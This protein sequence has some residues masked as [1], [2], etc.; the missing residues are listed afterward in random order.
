MHVLQTTTQARFLTTSHIHTQTHKGDLHIF[1]V[2]G[3]HIYMHSFL[4]ESMYLHILPDT[5][6]MH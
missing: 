6:V 1:K 2:Y 4:P 3:R 5:V